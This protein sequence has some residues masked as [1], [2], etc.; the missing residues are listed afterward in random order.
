ML[1]MR[2]AATPRRTPDAVAVE[3]ASGRDRTAIEELLRSTGLPTGGLDDALPTAFVAR[4]DGR[5]VGTAALEVRGRSALLRSVAVDEGLRGIGLGVRLTESALEL[6]RG[7][8]LEDV[9]LLTDLAARFYDRFGFEEIDRTSIPE[10]VQAS[11][12]FRGACAETAV[13][14]RKRLTEA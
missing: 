14:M 2:T 12:E 9:Y 7:S 8:G 11:A 5:V 1:R 10:A 6:A 4:V 3:R 13:A